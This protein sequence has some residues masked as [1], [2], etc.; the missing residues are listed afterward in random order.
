L[1]LLPFGYAGQQP[2]ALQAAEWALGGVLA[3]WLVSLL[4]GRAWPRI[5]W[6]YSI[7]GLA[8]VAYGWWAAR[9]SF[10]EARGFGPATVDAALSH[11]EMIWVSTLIGTL[12]FS[13]HLAAQPVW[14]VRL[15]QGLAIS[16]V[17]IALLGLIQKIG[18]APGIYWRPDWRREWGDWSYVGSFFATFRYH[19]NAGSFLNLLWPLSGGFFVAA[20]LR[21]SPLLVQGG[22]GM[23]FLLTFI[24]VFVNMSKAA[25]ALAVGLALIFA[26]WLGITHR[27]R[28]RQLNYWLLFLFAIGAGALFVFI[29]ERAGFA[30]AASH[31]KEFLGRWREPGW[32]TLAYAEYPRMLAEAGL[33]GF[34]PGTWRVKFP[35]YSP[36][37]W[38]KVKDFWPYAHQDFWQLLIEWGIPGAIGWAVLLFGALPAAL[39][40]IV[41]ADA[42]QAGRRR[43]ILLFCTVLSVLGVYAH[44]L[45][46][47][48]QHV[49]AIQL[50]LF[51]LL[52]TLPYGLVTVPLGNS[53]PGGQKL[54]GE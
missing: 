37:L 50:S 13:S 44:S 42:E 51:A 33:W 53:S 9:H 54:R 1:L 26:I 27:R 49:P 20:L 6:I 52:G 14:R 19:G 34:G 21:R 48:P 36:E 4:L 35:E 17:A 12:F 43:H 29:D 38:A 25:T 47:Y 10:G 28:L 5:P 32:R 16:G 23:A 46:D 18:G 22:W 39:I 11:Q 15:W 7:A 30:Q 40:R 41:R 45:L 31:W 24:A 8:L 3:L 2:W